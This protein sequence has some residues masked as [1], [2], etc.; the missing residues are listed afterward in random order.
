MNGYL[1]PVGT[2]AA[3]CMLSLATFGQAAAAVVP[4]NSLMFLTGL[5]T[6]VTAPLAKTNAGQAQSSFESLLID[7]PT[8]KKKEGFSDITLGKYPADNGT[9]RTLTLGSLGAT[10]TSEPSP[11]AG[12]DPFPGEVVNKSTDPA[13]NGRFDTT[14]YGTDPNGKW[15]LAAVTFTIDFVNPIEAFAFYVTDAGDFKGNVDLK[16]R[17]ADGTYTQTFDIDSLFRD[18]FSDAYKQQA[19]NNDNASAPDDANNGWLQFLG[20]YDAACGTNCYNQIEF[21]I[22]QADPND[23]DTWDYLG[24]D[25]LTIGKLKP[26]VDVPEPGSLAL[27][28]ASLLALGATRRRRQQA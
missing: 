22:S 2:V 23:P 15:W 21:I 25:D 5:D 20:F 14:N 19:E 3:A 13:D 27:V 11:P 26:A 10:V 16:L 1:R 9:N 17:R 8:T 6:V 28:G 4:T 7:D 24:F 18:K 12:V